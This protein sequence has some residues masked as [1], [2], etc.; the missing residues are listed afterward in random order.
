MRHML[1]LV[2]MMPL[3]IS[4]ALGQTSVT[5]ESYPVKLSSIDTPFAVQAEFSGKF[6]MYPY[7][8]ALEFKKTFIKVSENCPYKGRRLL[9]TLKVSLA[10]KTEKGWKPTGSAYSFPIQRVLK[11]NDSLDLGELKFLIPLTE[12]LDL[13]NHWFVLQ[14]DETVLDGS[15][16][17]SAEGA[18]FAHSDRKIFAR[19]LN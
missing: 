15:D 16:L 17:E 8:I 13:S 5:P 6:R 9:T 1:L 10:T 2:L 7:G 18:S 12:P 19:L 11:A 3:L 14:I 4:S